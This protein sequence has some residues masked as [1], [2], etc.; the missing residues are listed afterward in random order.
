MGSRF[1]ELQNEM[2]NAG[3]LVEN[4]ELG[5]LTRC[6]TTSDKGGQKSGWYRMFDDVDQVTC[7]YGDWRTGMRHIWTSS[8]KPRSPE[9]HL[10]M[11]RLIE[12]VKLEEEQARQNQWT[13]NRINLK[14]L[15]H[16]G[17]ELRESNSA[18]KYL[19]NR[20][21]QIPNSG[22]LK[23]HPSLNYWSDGDFVGEFPAMLAAVTNPTGDLVTV[24]R[25]F[26]TDDGHKAPVPTPKKLAPAAGSLRGASI[27]IGTPT[28]RQD[29]TLNLGIAEGVE[30][31]LAASKLF[32][33]PVWS[34]VSASNLKSFSPPASVKNIYIFADNDLNQVGQKASQELGERLTHAGHVVRIRTP[35]QAGKDW[36]DILVA[37]VASHV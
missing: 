20:G 35:E 13:I 37:K 9:Q 36:A 19:L 34:A 30:T 26:L 2:L 17:S 18:G 8:D 7:V 12:R 27:K 21:L 32:G 5:G 24:H 22:V 6:K 4:L 11:N 3:L 25:T 29:A 28:A 23:F 33:V 31:A 10:N 14:T 1:Y 16:S 15:W